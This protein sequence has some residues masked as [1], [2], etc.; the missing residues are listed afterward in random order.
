MPAARST[1]ASG[2][3]LRRIFCRRAG[4]YAGSFFKQARISPEQDGASSGLN[5]PNISISLGS[6]AEGITIL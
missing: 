3:S 1:I 2:V 5:C 4:E 6:V